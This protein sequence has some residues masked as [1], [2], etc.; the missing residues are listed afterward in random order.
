MIRILKLWQHEMVISSVM[1]WSWKSSKYYFFFSKNRVQNCSCLPIKL[2]WLTRLQFVFNAT[3]LA[4]FMPPLPSPAL[5]ATLLPVCSHL[6]SAGSGSSAPSAGYSA[7]RTCGQGDSMGTPG[8]T[9]AKCSH[10]KGTLQGTEILCWI[11]YK[12]QTILQDDFRMLGG[13]SRSFISWDKS[14]TSLKMSHVPRVLVTWYQLNFT[15]GTTS[16]TISSLQ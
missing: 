15:K 10:R 6:L 16:L 13:H 8:N 14:F 2:P 11:H 4:L 12:P 9:G 1:L 3:I 7:P 5:H